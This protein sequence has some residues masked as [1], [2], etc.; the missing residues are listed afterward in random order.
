MLEKRLFNRAAMCSVTPRDFLNEQISATSLFGDPNC[1]C[2]HLPS[3]EEGDLVNL[4][5]LVSDLLEDI[6]SECRLHGKGQPSPVNKFEAKSPLDCFSG[7]PLPLIDESLKELTDFIASV[8]CNS[9]KWNRECCDKGNRISV[10][11][12]GLGSEKSNTLNQGSCSFSED[13]GVCETSTFQEGSNMNQKNNSS[14]T[15]YQ[16]L[17][18]RRYDTKLQNLN[19][20]GQ[21]KEQLNNREG[22]YSKEISGEVETERNKK[23]EKGSSKAEQIRKRLDVGSPTS[24]DENGFKD[25]NAEDFIVIDECS[26]GVMEEEEKSCLTENDKDIRDSQISDARGIKKTSTEACGKESVVSLRGQEASVEL[27][28]KTQEERSGRT[29][30]SCEKTGIRVKG[31]SSMQPCLGTNQN[32]RARLRGKAGVGGSRKTGVK[33][34][35]KVSLRTSGKVGVMTSEKTGDETKGKAGVGV[36][37]KG[38]G[39]ADG[40]A[41]VGVSVGAKSNG[42]DDSGTNGKRNMESNRNLGVQTSGKIDKEGNESTCGRIGNSE[43]SNTEEREKIKSVSKE[44]EKMKAKGNRSMDVG[45][46]KEG[47]ESGDGNAYIIGKDRKN[48]QDIQIGGNDMYVGTEDPNVKSRG[49]ALTLNSTIEMSDIDV[50]E[51]HPRPED[52]DYLDADMSLAES[53]HNMTVED[54]L[55]ELDAMSPVKNKASMSCARQE[56]ITSSHSHRQQMEGVVENNVEL[57]RTSTP[58]K[59]QQKKQLTDKRL[60]SGKDRNGNISPPTDAQTQVAD[61]SEQGLSNINMKIKEPVEMDGADGAE[62]AVKAYEVPFVSENAEE[63]KDNED[64]AWNYLRLLETDEERYKM[65]RNKWKNVVIP[66][67]NKNLTYHSFRRTKVKA[68]EPLIKLNALKRKRCQGGENG[69]EGP[70]SKK[71]RA[72]NLDF[73]LQKVS[74]VINVV[75]CDFQEELS[76]SSSQKRSCRLEQCYYEKLNH[77]KEARSENIA[78]HKFYSGLEDQGTVSQEQ[79]EQEQFDIEQMYS[80]FKR[81]YSW[82]GK[83]FLPK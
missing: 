69:M 4:H 77:L 38:G 7:L 24:N 40:K 47:I 19:K 11:Y 28:R 1:C 23:I 30:G 35:G 25:I 17:L 62:D 12:Q 80:C 75:F 50:L 54:N 48:G 83:M 41:G 81:Y 60:D 58:T 56:I 52:R 32:T 42:K 44:D 73:N 39:G 74:R 18:K 20:A 72:V 78:L 68:A 46:N 43:K 33:V 59:P 26:E 37:G 65:V 22:V 66:D 61:F 8:S 76:R 15:D 34:A 57:Q 14:L 2:L 9:D 27:N 16:K 55:L 3:V 29:D 45:V 5:H 36:S 67:P 49:E 21:N 70:S 6:N 79:L 31:D 82:D 13:S 53:L 63:N 10:D 64:P 51:L 71:S